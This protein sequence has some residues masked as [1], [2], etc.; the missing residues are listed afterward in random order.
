M[1]LDDDIAFFAVQ[2]RVVQ[3]ANS[4]L[5]PLFE[6]LERP[7]NWDRGVQKIAADKVPAE[8]SWRRQFWDRYLA[9]FPNA[10]AD[11]GGGGHGSSRWRRVPGSK[12]IV[13]RWVG[14]ETVGVF[15][16]GERGVHTPTLYEELNVEH[17][18]L[19]ARLGTKIG[20]SEWYPF[21]IEREWNVRDP[22]QADQA[23][24]WLENQTNSFVEALQEYA[25]ETE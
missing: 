14:E 4:P 1:S 17:E 22:A 13:S 23:I 24:E 20:D 16:R 15:I 12:L 3:I 5:A 9:K 10:S 6:V 25:R 18:A 11:R 2:L 8:E 7:N 21:M 19:E